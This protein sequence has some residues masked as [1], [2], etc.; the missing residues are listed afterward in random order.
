MTPTTSLCVPTFGEDLQGIASLIQSTI[1]PSGS[2]FDEVVIVYPKDKRPQIPGV[3][4]SGER[5]WTEGE[6]E[7][8]RG[9]GPKGLNI[10]GIPT[11]VLD[12]T[13]MWT[14]ACDAARGTW[15]SPGIPGSSFDVPPASDA[16]S[17]TLREFLESVPD[18]V[19]DIWGPVE[20]APVAKG[21]P[22]TQI[23][24][25]VLVRWQA[26]W[27]WAPPPSVMLVPKRHNLGRS[28]LQPG[29]A[30]HADIA[31]MFAPCDVAWE[32][33]VPEVVDLLRAAR[34]AFALGDPLSG[35]EHGLW[36]VLLAPEHIGGY[37]EAGCAMAMLKRPDQ[38]LKWLR[39]GF[40]R[41]HNGLAF[42]P[43]AGY[44]P[45]THWYL[46]LAAQLT[47]PVGEVVYFLESSAAVM[48]WPSVIIEAQAARRAMD[49]GATS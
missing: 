34:L 19:S 33:K 14:L 49:A 10:V 21:V 20:F 4:W 38:A 9:Q 2:M 48:P 17:V 13:S 8:V 7:R 15:I 47:E 22:P 40:E 16:P 42:R 24:S 27:S 6:Q 36:A 37:L 12:V 39:R 23:I 31:M 28:A 25:P 32:S 44:F 30:R 5:S 18:D 29:L 41:T 46:W 11:E 26:G 3:T 45:E 35:L 1:R 43:M